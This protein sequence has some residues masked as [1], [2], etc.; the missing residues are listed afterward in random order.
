MV[1]AGIMGDT[2]SQSA[3]ISAK[4]RHVVGS[5][6]VI[7]RRVMALVSIEKYGLALQAKRVL[8]FLSAYIEARRLRVRSVLS[9][10]TLGRCEVRLSMIKAALFMMLVFKREQVG[11]SEGTLI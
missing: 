10:P 6:G 5:A 7:Q 2:L 8:L 9:W 3:P 1:R 11:W 4:R